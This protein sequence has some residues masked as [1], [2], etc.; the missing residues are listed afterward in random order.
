MSSDELRSKLSLSKIEIPQDIYLD[1]RTS[2]TTRTLLKAKNRTAG[3]YRFYQ[4]TFPSQ[5]IVLTPQ[6]IRIN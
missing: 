3:H 1:S 4:P 2:L 6:K 5:A